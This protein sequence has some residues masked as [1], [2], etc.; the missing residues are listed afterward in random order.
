VKSCAEGNQ[1]ET[2]PLDHLVK[3]SHSHKRD[4][5]E[6][7]LEA[8]PLIPF[9][10]RFC[11]H[12]LRLRCD[13]KLADCPSSLVVLITE[14]CTTRKFISPVDLD[15]KGECDVVETCVCCQDNGNLNFTIDVNRVVTILSRC[16]TNE[17]ILRLIDLSIKAEHSSPKLII[18]RSSSKNCI[19]PNQVGL[20]YHCSCWRPSART[21]TVH[22]RGV[23]IPGQS[24]GGYGPKIEL[25]GLSDPSL[26][27]YLSCNRRAPV[28][29]GGR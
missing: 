15:T 23:L 16:A 12:R 22:S 1:S 7:K 14:T 24:A 6:Q 5:R 18:D 28:E 17:Q 29:P 25:A 20:D 13:F 27:E 4:K 2:L 11:I 8:I 21:H 3:S 19:L 26:L 9:R 10:L